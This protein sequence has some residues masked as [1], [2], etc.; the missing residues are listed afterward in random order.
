LPV[1]TPGET[2]WTSAGPIVALGCSGDAVFTAAPNR[3]TGAAAAVILLQTD[4]GVVMIDAGMQAPDPGLSPVVGD[5]LGREVAAYLAGADL[6]EAIL[7]RK[8]PAGHVTPYVGKLVR[9]RTLRGTLEQYQ[10]GSIGEVLAV[11]REYRTWYLESLRQK[12]VFERSSWE[13]TQPI[14]P[15]NGIREQRWQQ[16]LESAIAAAVREATPPAL[17]VVTTAGAF[18]QV[19][20]PPVAP[21]EQELKRDAAGAVDLTEMDW[22][23]ADDEQY[24]ALAGSQVGVFPA[25]GVLYRPATIAPPAPE[26]PRSRSVPELKAGGEHGPSLPAPRAVTPWAVMGAIGKE[27]AMLVRIKAGYAVLVD[28]GGVPRALTID[29]IAAAQREMAVRID[30]ILVTHPHGD[31]VRNIIE[32]IKGDAVRGLPPIRAENLV[33]SHAWKDVGLIKALR[34]NDQA[35]IDLGFGP[36]WLP[37]DAALKGEGTIHLPL[38]VDGTQVDVY[39]RPEAHRELRAAMD[40]ASEKKASGRRKTDKIDSTKFD[41][42]SFL[43]VIGN[44]S[45]PNRMA[46]LGDLRG[47]DIVKMRTDLG[48]DRFNAVFKNVRVVQGLGHHLSLTAGTTARD[49]AGMEALLE[50]TLHQ[51]GELTVMV[52]SRE[53]FAFDGTPTRAGPEGALVHYL[54]RQGVRVVFAGKADD[55]VA[56][57]ARLDSNARVRATGPS[58]H[59]FDAADPRVR[60]MWDRIALLREAKKTAG[61][62]HGAEALGMKDEVLLES[63]IDR[64]LDALLAVATDLRDLAGR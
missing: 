14:A 7:S 22:E 45:S 2:Y 46:I 42:A 6:G 55:T 40:E 24:V 11:Q 27:G 25:R 20:D 51:N 28:A 43:Y 16:H 13:S 21:V 4:G 39:T 10:D 9:I 8:A 1:I 30:K 36:R 50:A 64:E 57:A 59:V 48:G 29:G 49:V 63:S 47:A 32:L 37:S 18:T 41:S 54:E 19:S 26:L 35:L 23:P 3:D 61:K 44:E 52:Q 33:V 38:T 34:A 17:A 12:L 58:M 53:G 15:N 31:H 56:S 60:E 62:V 5:E